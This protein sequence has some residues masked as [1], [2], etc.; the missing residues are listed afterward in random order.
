MKNSGASLL[1]FCAFAMLSRVAPAIAAPAVITVTEDVLR[2]ASEVPPL[3]VNNWGNVGAV[4]YSAGNLIKDPGFEPSMMRKLY[5]V[6]EVGKDR[7]H[8]WVSLDGPG[9]SNYLLYTD[10]TFSGARMRAYR[11]LDADGNSLPYN[12]D[13]SGN[14]IINS[15]NAAQVQPVFDSR[16]LP[17]GA[18]GFPNGG[19][20]APSP[21]KYK[22]WQDMGKVA[23]AALREKWR[24]YYEGDVSLQVDDVVIFQKQWIWP[25]TD[26]FHPRI[27]ERGISS[28][29]SIVNERGSL[30]YQAHVG[31]TP[32]EMDAGVSHLA[33]EPKDEEALVWHKLFGN[34][35]RGDAGWYGQLE[36]GARYHYEAWLKVAADG[37]GKAA[38]GFVDNGSFEKSYFGTKLDREF[39]V[40]GKWQRYSFTFTA[41]E[42][43]KTG[44]IGGAAI[45]YKGDKALFVDDVSLQPVYGDGDEK[46]PFVPFHRL[47]KELA[48]CQPAQGPKGAQR[49]WVGLTEVPMKSI[50]S[51]INGNTVGISWYISV[52]PA[53]PTTIPRVLSLL[54][55]TGDSPA[56]RM[57]PWLVI[58]VM[59][60]EEEYRALIEYLAAPYD[61]EKDTAESRPFAHLRYTQRGHGRPWIDDFKEIIIEFGNENW[62]NRIMASWIGFGRYGGVHQY[63]KEY[64][65]FCRYYIEQMQGSPYWDDRITFSLGGNYSAGVTEDGRVT[66]YGQE[67]S[68]ACGLNQYE[69]HATYVGPRWEMNEKSATSIDDTGFQRTLLCYITRTSEWEKQNAAW[70]RLQQMGL[71]HRLAAYEGGPSGFGLRAKN[72]EE[73]RAGEVY[74]KSKAMGV[75]ALDGW[76][77]AY[78]LG[79]TYQCYLS[80][81]QG[82]WWSSH[83]SF[84]HGFRPSPGFLAMTMRNRAMAGDLLAVQVEDNPTINVDV[85]E[86][87]GRG[88]KLVK[89]D[90]DLIGAYA[91]GDKNQL[92]VALLNRSLTETHEVALH[93]PVKT[94]KSIEH[95]WLTGDPRDT[96]LDAYKVE[97]KNEKMDT[98]RLQDGRMSVT[99]PPGSTTV[100]VFQR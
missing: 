40:D 54:E 80:F 29:W 93:L 63:G 15:E 95:W 57:V 39:S 9:T 11:M 37:T 4:K 33:I 100:Y 84:A 79:W 10:G 88:A 27:G 76:L 1:A 21:E 42:P 41:P 55:Q 96:N 82:R 98:A 2:P 17:K 26:D 20:L 51:W 13:R 16:V 3:G 60:D 94:P 30:R 23:K 32:D 83:T 19:W 28:T 78:R 59:Y 52:R 31:P 67:A 81:N 44:G 68:Q 22:E 85:P 12:K 73:D 66:G 49:S 91:M 86:G 65:L 14:P 8:H 35:T 50:L 36:P 25:S 75:A 87:R 47:Q 58:Q 61:P 43:P 77:D 62:H 46:R 6:I 53:A 7:G 56:D 69:G 97:L 90:I 24:V 89:K 92:S 72:K 48:D 64:G 38:L 18:P 70:K 5:R 45:Q 71:K 34:I 99:L 74:G